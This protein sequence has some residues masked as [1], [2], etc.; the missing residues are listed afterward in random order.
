MALHAYP[1][2]TRT[3]THQR[4]QR[5]TRGIAVAKSPRLDSAQTSVRGP[6]DARG[7]ASATTGGETRL[8]MLTNIARQGL[9][10]RQRGP[11]KPRGR[12]GSIAQSIMDQRRA[13]RGA[14]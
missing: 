12:R 5:P 2:G 10:N 4:T 13:Q 11:S 7:S 8:G 9:A 14:S 6:S 3:G 1:S